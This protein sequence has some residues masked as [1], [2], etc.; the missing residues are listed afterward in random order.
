MKGLLDLPGDLISPTA[1]SLPQTASSR[2]IGETF[3]RVTDIVLALSGVVLLAPLLIICYF[4][5]VIASPG[6]VFF[7]HRRVGFKGKYFECL[8]FRTMV[9]DASERLRELLESDP[10]AAAE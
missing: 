3:K 4:A 6:P 7:G 1:K 9:P 5:T 8:K 10:A 2:P